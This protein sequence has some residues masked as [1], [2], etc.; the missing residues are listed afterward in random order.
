MAWYADYT[1]DPQKN[2]KSSYST[3]ALAAG[4]WKPYQVFAIGGIARILCMVYSPTFSSMFTAPFADYIGQANAVALSM[5]PAGLF[6]LK[7]GDV[8]QKRKW[9]ESNVGLAVLTISC[10]VLM[11]VL[12]AF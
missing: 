5:I 12:R 1:P 2:A 4:A 6:L 9:H 8:I 10:I 11:L 3:I 7:L